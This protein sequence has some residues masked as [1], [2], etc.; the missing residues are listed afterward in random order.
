MSAG[1]QA[2]RRLSLFELLGLLGRSVHPIAEQPLGDQLA[3][4][5]P[6]LD[7]RVDPGAV[8]G[9][10]LGQVAVD[11]ERV[12]QRRGGEGRLDLPVVLDRRA[13]LVDEDRRGAGGLAR[14]AGPGCAV[15][16]GQ[17]PDAEPQR[18]DD[19]VADRVCRP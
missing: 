3:G 14:V 5:D 16:R 19:R 18:L 9:H 2:R 15:D 10:L 7:A 11:D 17:H 12:G 6:G 8:V 1:G 13:G 4:R